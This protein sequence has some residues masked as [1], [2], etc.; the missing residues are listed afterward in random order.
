MRNYLFSKAGD[1]ED[2]VRRGGGVVNVGDQRKSGK[3]FD[4]KSFGE[5]NRKVEVRA[6]NHGKEGLWVDRMKAV[7][8]LEGRVSSESMRD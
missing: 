6:A 7:W 8:M 4:V 1:R 2:E 3:G 5:G